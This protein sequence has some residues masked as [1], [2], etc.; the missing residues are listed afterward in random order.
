MELG[1]SIFQMVG[2]G[3]ILGI[4]YLVSMMLTIA[5][6]IGLLIWQIVKLVRNLKNKK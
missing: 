5:V 3:S 1:T 2:I 4:I 6:V